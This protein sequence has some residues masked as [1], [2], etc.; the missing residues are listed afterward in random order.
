MFGTTSAFMHTLSS[1]QILLSK[2]SGLRGMVLPLQLEDS[3]RV[4]RGNCAHHVL[5][6]GGQ[7]QRGV[8]RDADLKAGALSTGSYTLRELILGC[9]RISKGSRVLQLASRYLLSKGV[10][11]CSGRL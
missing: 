5:A 3:A 9:Y 2:C 1:I 10:P 8:S 6:A 11:T 7:V 4:L